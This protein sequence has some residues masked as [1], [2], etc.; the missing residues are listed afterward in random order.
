MS[1]AEHVIWWHVYPLGAVGAPIREREEGLHHRLPRLEA[2]LDHVVELGCS[3]VLLGPIF[4][5]T[6]HGYDTVDH[7]RI[8][9]RLGDDADFD[10]FVA[11]AKRRGLAVMLDGVFNHVGTEHPLALEHSP[12]LKRNG[13][14]LAVWEGHGGLVEFDHGNPAVADLVVDIMLHWLRRGIAGW[15][16]DV[17]YSVPTAFW[18]EVAGRV[19]QEFP[20]A[21]FLGEVL[22]GDFGAF[23]DDSTLDSVTAYELWKATWSSIKDVN[24]W[25]LA[26]ALQRH[27]EFSQ[28]RILNTFVGNHDVSRI[29][30]LAGDAG[31]VLAATTLF[32]LPGMPSVYYGDEEA[33]RGERAEGFHADDPIR[34]ALPD[35]PDQLSDLGS[36]LFPLYQHLIG[37]RRRHPWLTRANLEVVGKDNGWIVYACTHGADRVEVELRLDPKP[38]AFVRFSDGENWEWKGQA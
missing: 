17:A 15:R 28:G 26:W 20:D 2:W 1:L 33:F 36:W 37:M 25:E 22:H 8:D 14:Q 31:A 4:A 38:E 16:L 11:E 35:S 3:G 29:A 6:S 32:T 13:D 12:L 10:H 27:A 30:S 24:F 21:L 19:R 9:P 5:S 34:P 18:R 23:V 7:Y